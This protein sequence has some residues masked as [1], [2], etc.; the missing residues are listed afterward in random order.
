M[1]TIKRKRHRPL[2]LWKTSKFDDIVLQLCN[3]VNE[4]NSIEKWTKGFILP[5]SKKGD[6]RIAKNYRCIDQNAIATKVYNALLLNHTKPEIKKSL[7]KNQ[8]GFK[9]N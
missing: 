1:K 7:W 5:F 6:L 2:E 3:V 8:K 9:R 4:K